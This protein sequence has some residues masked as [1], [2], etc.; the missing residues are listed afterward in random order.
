MSRSTKAVIIRVSVI[1]LAVNAV[2]S[3]FKLAAGIIARS[4]AMVSDAIHSA[5]DFLSTI[6]VMASAVLAGKKA[7][8]EH[9]YG[10]ERFEYVGAIILACVLAACG[11]GIGYSG[12]RNIIAG[13]SA[14]P[15]M[16]ALVAAGVSIVLKEGMY[17]YTR[18]YAKKIGSGALMADAW[19]HRSD[20]L[21]SVGSLIGIGG[22]MLGLPILDPIAGVVISLMIVKASADIFV[23]AV[24][25]MEDRACDEET[26]GRIKS[27]VARVAGVEGVDLLKTRLFGN[28]VYVDVEISADAA[29]S[30]E[31]AHA[32]AEAVHAKVEEEFPSVKHCMVHVNPRPAEDKLGKDANAE[33]RIEETA[34]EKDDP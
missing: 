29:L 26:A 24:K 3:A 22:A 23:D 7:D 6:V 5:S 19:H 32:I 4:D 17:W 33:D 16:L 10:H 2:L 13:K 12:V 20:A 11:I 9:P 21:S 28:R 14:A 27:A 8:K 18:H 15:G 30:L 1:S 34:T 31:G 25:K